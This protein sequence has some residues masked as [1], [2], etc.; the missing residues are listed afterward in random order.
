[1]KTYRVPKTADLWHPAR[2]F[3]PPTNLKK[4]GKDHRYFSVVENQRVALW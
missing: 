1:M 3:L 4:D 2:V